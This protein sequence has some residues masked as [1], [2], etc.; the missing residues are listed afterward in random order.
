[1]RGIGRSFDGSLF[2]K[3]GG[4][5]RGIGAVE[6]SGKG[7]GS[8]GQG[9]VAAIRRVETEAGPLD[10]G[11]DPGEPVF[12]AERTT[13]R[14]GQAITHVRRYFARGHRKTTRY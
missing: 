4:T 1:M 12:T 7:H 11:E 9:V 5:R 3:S 8:E 2:E 14:E 10:H 6:V 13:W